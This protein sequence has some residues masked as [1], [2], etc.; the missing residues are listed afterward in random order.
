MPDS[1]VSGSKPQI[2]PPTTSPKP[3]NSTSVG[4]RVG[5][6]GERLAGEHLPAV[7]RAREDRL[8]RPVAVLG[9]D[10]VAGDERG[11]Q[12]E[13][14]D[15]AERSA[16]RAGSPGRT[17]ARSCRTGC[18]PG[19]RCSSTRAKM[20]ISRH[21]QGGAEADVGA[22]LGAQLA[23]LP[24]VDRAHAGAVG[25]GAAARDGDGGHARHLLGSA[26][27]QR[28]RRVALG[29]PEE[30]LLQRRRAR[31]RA[32]RGRCRRRRA[33]SESAATARSSAGEREAAA[34]A[35]SRMPSAR[36]GDRRS[37]GR[38]RSSAARSGRRS[39]AISS[40]SAPS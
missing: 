4:E 31:A 35:T 5:E 9:G 39:M 34:P 36:A 30:Q 3:T 12:R 29:E 14:P 22:L 20:K 13:E 2:R 19:R 40:S 38:R 1:E 24:G 10:D 28:R 7:D 27:R 37:R 15:R 21:E 17:R 6:R 11:D 25:A 33:S 16:R 8:Q 32:R 23:Q 18:P 26:A